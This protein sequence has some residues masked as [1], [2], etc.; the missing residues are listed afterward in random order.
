MQ[1]I[2]PVFESFGGGCL[3]F[4]YFSV[5]H[6]NFLKSGLLPY[7]KIHPF[8]G[9]GS[10]YFC[11]CIQWCNQSK[12]VHTIS[13]QGTFY[14]LL[15]ILFLTRSTYSSYQHFLSDPLRYHLGTGKCTLCSSQSFYKCI[16]SCNHHCNRDGEHSIISYNAVKPVCNHATLRPA[17]ATSISTSWCDFCPCTFAVYRIS[18][19]RNPTVV[20]DILYLA[21]LI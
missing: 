9:H 19:K 7:N 5:W 10:I 6:Y 4:L 18:D 16:Q 11:E 17:H 14:F 21:S 15:C 20:C 2:C 1:T 12:A 3:C 13:Y 8:K